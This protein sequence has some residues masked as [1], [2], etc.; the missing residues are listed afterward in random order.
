MIGR[1]FLHARRGRS[2]ALLAMLS[3]ATIAD[4]CAAQQEVGDPEAG[5]VVFQQCAS[6]HA[7]GP[8]AATSSGGP[9][10]NGVVGR[11]SAGDKE[12]NYSPQMRSARLVWDAPTLAR[13]LT[14][15]KR[16]VPGTRMLY[17]G[18]SSPGEVADVIA[19]ISRYD[20]AGA[21]KP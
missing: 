16:T 1:A 11:R 8:G 3:T 21:S 19:Y 7:I 2:A 4:D 17:N 13:F 14:A 6:C 10:L 12:Y 15:P 9:S 18:L 20:E 5:K